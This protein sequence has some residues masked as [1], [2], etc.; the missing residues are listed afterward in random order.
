LPTYREGFPNT[1]LEAASMR[2]P[3]VATR[4]PGCV[5]AVEDGV[6]GTLVAA[7]DAVALADAVRRYLRCPA[8]R[9]RHGSAGRERVERAFQQE[10]IW[11]AVLGEYDR[12]LAAR[13]LSRRGAVPLQHRSGSARAAPA[14]GRKASPTTPFGALVV[15]LD[16]ELHWGVRDKHPAT[17][18]YR[19]T[20]LNEWRV[21]PRILELFEEFDI[22]ATWAT[23]GFLFASSRRELE[24][25]SPAVR[26]RY[27]NAALSP[28]GEPLGRDESDDPLHFAPSL[29]RRI[30]ATARQ[31]I[32]THTFSHYYCLEA[33]Q[34]RDEFRADLAS[35][36]ALARE[37]GITLRSIVFPRN[38][39]NPDYDAVLRELGVT[40]YRGMQT[41][42]M[43]RSKRM[44][45]QLKRGGRLID[46]YVPLSGAQTVAWHQVLQPSGLCNVPGTHVVRAYSGRTRALEPLRARR[47]VASLERA[48]RRGEIVHVWWHPHNFSLRTD[49]SLAFVRTVLEAFARL[50]SE[51]GMQSLAM[52]DVAD[53][54]AGR[55][56]V[57]TRRRA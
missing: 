52:G 48:A 33:G 34:G 26:P 25:F 20:L 7:R 43:W 4:V 55:A 17:S 22:A 2:L 11:E 37:Q 15:S 39:H 38:Q 32:G 31:E 10:A 35:A 28:Y 24:R 49:E 27:A 29:I 40:C 9:R 14:G 19:Q 1:P 41:G 12:L 16:F 57:G 47:I 44:P 23:V 53:L 56:E 46:S 21:V 36:I 6:T 54:V 51:T 3:V 5:D 13:G 45:D 42:W 18:G 30:R 50:R 8:M